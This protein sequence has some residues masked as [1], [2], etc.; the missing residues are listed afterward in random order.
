MALELSPAF[1]QLGLRGGGGPR[2][3]PTGDMWREEFFAH[4]GTVDQTVDADK[5]WEKIM[6]SAD[7]I[8]METLGD[9][10]DDP[11][12]IVSAAGT[13][14][15]RSSYELLLGQPNQTTDPLSRQ[16][17][18]GKGALANTL[19]RVARLR[20]RTV[21]GQ[22]VPDLD[23]NGNVRPLL[24]AEGRVVFVD[25]FDTAFPPPEPRP[26]R[27]DG[28]EPRLVL[29]DKTK[30][31]FE[32]R[33]RLEVAST[34]SQ[35]LLSRINTDEAWRGSE[36]DWTVQRIQLRHLRDRGFDYM[37]DQ[38]FTTQ[39][40]SKILVPRY[41]NMAEIT[42]SLSDDDPTYP[43]ARDR[44]NILLLRRLFMSGT[45]DTAFDEIASDLANA[46]ARDPFRPR[47]PATP[48]ADL[49]PARRRVV[50]GSLN[51]T[52]MSGARTLGAAIFQTVEPVKTLVHKFFN[53][54]EGLAHVSCV[55]LTFGDEGWTALDEHRIPNH[56]AKDLIKNSGIAAHLHAQAM[57]KFMQIADVLRPLRR[58]LE[59][60]VHLFE[61]GGQNWPPRV[62]ADQLA[63][64]YNYRRSRRGEEDVHG[65]YLMADP[66]KAGGGLGLGLDA[67]EISDVMLNPIRAMVAEDERAVE[68]NSESPDLLEFRRGCLEFSKWM[69]ET[70][71]A[72]LT[73]LWQVVVQTFL[74]RQVLKDFEEV[75]EGCYQGTRN[76]QYDEWL[77][78]FKTASF[79]D[80][81][82]HVAG[83][84]RDWRDYY[85]SN[86]LVQDGYFSQRARFVKN[87][88]E[89]VRDT[90][91]KVNAAVALL[92]HLLVDFERVFTYEYRND[93]SDDVSF[94]NENAPGRPRIY[95]FK[96]RWKW[97]V[98]D[99]LEGTSWHFDRTRTSVTETLADRAR[100]VIMRAMRGLW[101][102]RRAHRNSFVTLQNNGRLKP[103]TFPQPGGYA[104]ESRY[105]D[106]ERIYD[107]VI[108][109]T[110]IL[111]DECAK[112]DEHYTNGHVDPMHADKFDA[113]IRSCI[114]KV[115]DNV[116]GVNDSNI[117]RAAKKLVSTLEHSHYS[118]VS[119]PCGL[120]LGR[121]INLTGGSKRWGDDL[122]ALWLASDVFGD[123]VD[124][125]ARRRN[126]S[127]EVYA[128][129]VRHQIQN[130]QGN[131]PYDSASET[132]SE[133]WWSR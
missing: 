41:F 90:M 104:A 128:Q 79:Y 126:K 64:L 9:D 96:F 26:P 78:Q 17:L 114:D 60:S 133:R 98:S 70:F 35:I 101:V 105:M 46:Y 93:L 28:A 6:E 59:A 54:I 13:I 83:I 44:R 22:I 99:D 77:S 73:R 102:L 100:T 108:G 97:A 89:A 42:P 20:T 132:A 116:L 113:I 12:T 75:C 4:T 27:E 68:L 81:G 11:P 80:W 63:M 72:R 38:A 82:L 57:C 32:E 15:K 103:R 49:D 33:F 2:A 125:H 107:A 10:F 45:V 1:T 92:V 48:R 21:D 67:S 124:R 18:W 50:G 14:M 122:N 56:V 58:P 39:I 84:F 88:G 51:G 71:E 3:A 52:V 36:Q 76:L 34:S 119:M 16:P 95:P 43:A 66:L 55:H 87:E 110:R 74:S 40:F 121:A 109:V 29:D 118:V 31:T 131:Y 106:I 53:A 61:Y 25:Y 24:D 47:Q 8:S 30:K 127:M 94:E 62:L 7:P 120:D 112:I 85:N 5:T 37:L 23:A 111:H 91:E 123:T 115:S 86:P 129:R 117:I 65:L 19:A 130:S 69:L